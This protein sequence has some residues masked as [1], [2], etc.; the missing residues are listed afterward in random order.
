M[1]VNG[2]APL[3]TNP[4]DRMLTHSQTLDD[5]IPNRATKSKLEV[6]AAIVFFY[7][8]RNYKLFGSRA[9]SRLCAAPFVMIFLALSSLTALVCRGSRME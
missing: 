6:G 1:N 2:V 7:D 4:G 9:I 5:F 3:F 8:F